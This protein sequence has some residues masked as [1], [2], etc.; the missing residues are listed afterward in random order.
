MDRII[1][2]KESKQEHN[3]KYLVKRNFTEFCDNST[4]HGMKYVGRKKDIERILW[5]AVCSLLLLVC[6]SQIHK[7]VG[8]W[9]ESPLVLLLDQKHSSINE[10]PFP[11]VTIC[12]Q[13]MPNRNRF[14]YSDYLMRF[15]DDEKIK[16][17][18]DDDF[19]LFEITSKFCLHH[20]IEY[21]D[22]IE[23]QIHKLSFFQNG[24]PNDL[25]EDYLLSEHFQLAFCKGLTTEFEP[26]W[27]CNLRFTK[28]WLKEGL[29]YTF[30]MFPYNE[31]FNQNVTFPLAL[32]PNLVLPKNDPERTNARQMLMDIP[33][34]PLPFHVNDRRDRLYVRT[35]L[36]DDF[37]DPICNPEFHVF[38]HNPYEIPWD[39]HT[40]GHHIN[41]LKFKKNIFSI[42]PTVT[43]TK[44][45]L[46]EF[47]IE[48]RGC[49]F[50]NE[51][52]LKY[53]QRYSHS[54]CELECIT[55]AFLA[56]W[57]QLNCTLHWMPRFSDRELCKFEPYLYASFIEDVIGLQIDK[58]NCLPDCNSIKYD[59]KITRYLTPSFNDHAFRSKD[60]LNKEMV[61]MY[62]IMNKKLNFSM[63]L[64]EQVKM[65]KESNLTVDFDFWN[66]KFS[67]I[68]VSYESSRFLGMKRHLAY[69]FTDFVSQ[70]GGILGCF[71]G[72]S[73]FS[74]IE[75]I[76][77]WG[78]KIFQ[79]KNNDI[80]QEEN[81]NAELETIIEKKVQQIMK[82]QKRH[83]H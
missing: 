83:S 40:H 62:L 51:R 38:I 14:N 49:Y 41:V 48:D 67:E 66:W 34:Q 16:S 77:F 6:A 25:I 19:R 60:L 44:D 46:R 18:S 42:T 70:I 7:T 10:I 13:R 24:I 50:D 71:L 23:N 79:K 5:I 27:E 20:V 4:I 36:Y 80:A 17:F 2:P 64:D 73:I 9:R 75:I 12:P 43:H 31:I 22:S 61:K 37:T 1:S 69:T 52:Q 54:N 45:E 76:Y 74:I 58:C 21:L 55:D 65:I 57:S 56:D 15:I 8:K 28:I 11:A 35:R 39:G 47:P 53:F 33:E 59:V 63:T 78:I 68:E 26:G 82:V 3:I 81:Q 72:I 29:C 30:N 32:H